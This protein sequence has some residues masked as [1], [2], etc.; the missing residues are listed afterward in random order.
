[1]KAKGKI[2]HPI[3]QQEIPLEEP[4]DQGVVKIHENVISAIVR[5]ATC[6]VEGVVRLAGST[7]LDNIAEIVGSRRIHDRAI[8]TD[9]EGGEVSIQVKINIMYGMS[10]PAL[11][12]RV[13]TA[14]I[15]AVEE[16]TGM[17]V[18]RV[19]VFIQEVETDSE[20]DESEDEA[21]NEEDLRDK[22]DSN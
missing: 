12:S 1:M 6:S 17:K 13:Q 19:D 11:A 5:K 9:I 4:P 20:G 16:M 10:V 18:T 2:R 8:T 7:F 14:V 15:E 21:P 3:Y 22:L